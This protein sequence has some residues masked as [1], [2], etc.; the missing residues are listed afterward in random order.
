MV[1]GGT[2]VACNRLGPADLELRCKAALELWRGGGYDRL[3]LCGGTCRPRATQTMAESEIMRDWF[4]QH[5]VPYGSIFI[6][7]SSVDSYQNI[8][9]GLQVL[10][11]RGL[12][13]A[14]ITLVSQWQH[15]ARMRYT[16]WRVHGVK[17][18]TLSLHYRI[19][20]L[21]FMAE[22]LFALYHRYDP[23]GQKRLAISNRMARRAASQL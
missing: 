1:P 11:L 10:R 18:R 22:A 5:D 6:E 2:I 15:A 19:G 4:V 3:L 20:L 8:E 21:R 23:Y 14:E 7:V 17:V 16:F 9:Y 12:G 13:D